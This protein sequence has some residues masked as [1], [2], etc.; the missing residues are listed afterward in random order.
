MKQLA[1]R[2]F[3]FILCLS[4]SFLSCAMLPVIDVA[5]VVQLGS[6]LAQLESQTKFIQQGVL[7][8]NPQKWAF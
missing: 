3:L 4:S 6:Q 1:L 2:G 5:A 8:K 7:W